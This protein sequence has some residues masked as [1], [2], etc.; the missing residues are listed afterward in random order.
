[1]RIAQGFLQDVQ[2]I[3]L[4]S[5]NLL[6]SLNGQPPRQVVLFVFEKTEQGLN[7]QLG[8]CPRPAECLH[9]VAANLAVGA[10]QVADQPRHAGR[11]IG[12]NEPV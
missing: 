6:K 9:G 11:V 3:A 10:F 12:N 2:V 8:I 7:G 4:G 5:S 1:M